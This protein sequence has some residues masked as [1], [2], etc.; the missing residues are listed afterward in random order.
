MA[1]LGSKLF[2]DG[3]VLNAAQVNGY[4]M[5]QTIMRFATTAARDAAFGGIGEATLS[6]GMFCYLDD[7]NSLQ[8]Y[9]GSAWVEIANI[10]DKGAK[11]I[12]GYAQSTTTFTSPSAAEILALGMSV[13]FTAE[14]NRYYRITY[15]E[16]D[17]YTGINSQVTL[18][19]RQT[20]LT[21][22]Q[23]QRTNATGQNHSAVGGT[24]Q[25]IKT[26]SA[27]SIT[28]VATVALTSGTSNYTRNTD[29]VAFLVVEDLG[30]V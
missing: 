15:F 9:S 23:L 4:L 29:T 17:I 11:G 19:I 16:P 12:V 21:G 3:S 27:G 18:R 13:T 22:T 10:T 20:N 7:S 8:V 28:L 25:L 1:G 26:F 14:A 6:E 30:P 2:T 5:D 24:C